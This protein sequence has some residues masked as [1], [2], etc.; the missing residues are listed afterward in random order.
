LVAVAGGSWT[1]VNAP[2]VSGDSLVWAFNSNTSAG[3]GPLSL[4]FLGNAVLA[5]GLLIQEDAPGAF[6]AQVS[7]FA[8]GMSLGTESVTSA[9]GNPVF[10]GAQ[11]GTADITQ[12]IFSLTSCSGQ[13]CDVKD[14]A[15]DTLRSVN[16]QVVPAPLIGFG[17]PVFLAVGGLLFG[18]N[19]FKRSRRGA[20]LFG[21][22]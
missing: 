13:N 10:I 22:A 9:T 14:F 19:L 17:L 15:V 1:P 11:D 20:G 18:A 5:G 21:I 8:G 2:F 4:S 16:A 3:T 12:L 6:T 7:A